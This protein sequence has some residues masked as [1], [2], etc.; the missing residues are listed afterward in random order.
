MSWLL[1]SQFFQQ[2]RRVARYHRICGYILGYDAAGA[3]DGVFTHGD[4][5]QQGGA[6]TDRRTLPDDRLFTYPIRLGLQV[7]AGS[8]RTGIEVVDEGNV[9]ADENVIFDDDPLAD[10]GMAGD[11]AVVPDGAA[12]QVDELRQ[13]DVRSHLHVL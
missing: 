12:I 8:G 6:R 4:A 9:M 13:L 2:P 11:L 5:A 1:C 7:S 3:D 10:E